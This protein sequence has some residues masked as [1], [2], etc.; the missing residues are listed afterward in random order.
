MHRILS[1][2]FFL[3]LATTI[4]LADALAQSSAGRGAVGGAIIG[5]AIGG[6]RGAAVGAIRWESA[7][8]A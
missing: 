5:G 4:P 1:L 8:C 6:R 3:A 2:F 7:A